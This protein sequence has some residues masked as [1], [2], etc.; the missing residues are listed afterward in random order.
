M[1]G[2]SLKIKLLINP[3][4]K[5]GDT[6]KLIDGSG[7]SL[8]PNQ[9]PNAKKLY[10]V[11]SYPEYGFHSPLKTYEYKVIET[12]INDYVIEG[13]LGKT[14][15]LQDIL[16]TC[17]GVKLRTFSKSVVKVYNKRAVL[18]NIDK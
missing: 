13:A 5:V 3:E 12:G 10:I 15:Y 1:K 18:L 11:H 9:Y 7:L 17:N 16:I 4:I 8:D 6:V 2:P 14:A